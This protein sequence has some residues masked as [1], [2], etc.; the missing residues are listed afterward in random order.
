VEGCC[1]LALLLAPKEQFRAIMAVFASVE[2]S[3]L[4]APPGPDSQATTASSR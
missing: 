3:F 1:G 4:L 2:A